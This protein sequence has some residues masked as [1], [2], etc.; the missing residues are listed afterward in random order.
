M[1]SRRVRCGSARSS[2]THTILLRKVPCRFSTGFHVICLM[3]TLCQFRKVPCRFTTGFRQI[4][5]SCAL[6]RVRC[7]SVGLPL[8]IYCTSVTCHAHQ[9]IGTITQRFRGHAPLVMQ[10]PNARL[11][12]SKTAPLPAAPDPRG[13][14]EAT[15]NHNTNSSNIR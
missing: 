8:M 4:H 7:G 14:A 12:A 10:E 3:F 6:H 2:H 13:R 5:R 1:G 11:L 15:S 9:R